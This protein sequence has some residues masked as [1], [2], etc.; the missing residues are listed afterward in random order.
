[1]INNVKKTSG[2]A[3]INIKDSKGNNKTSGS[4]VTGD[5]VVIGNSK[6][7][8]S[9]GIVIYGDVNGDGKI[10]KDDCLGIL[11]HLKGYGDLKSYYAMAADNNKDGKIDKDDCLGI[12]R[13]LKGYTNLNK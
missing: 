1:L 2:Y 3:R 9:F 8:E 4:F 5:V 6:E 13:H 7:E 11:R 12:L 10:D